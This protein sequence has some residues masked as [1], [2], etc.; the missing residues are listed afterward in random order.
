MA[1]ETTTMTEEITIDEIIARI[2]D[3]LAQSDSGEWIVEIAN[4]V[5]I[6]KFTYTEDEIVIVEQEMSN[7]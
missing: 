2:S 1:E 3:G 6:G 5:L 7:G 4:L